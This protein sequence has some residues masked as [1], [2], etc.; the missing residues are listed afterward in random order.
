ML[1]FGKIKKGKYVK[2]IYDC[3]LLV[4]MKHKYLKILLVIK[5]WCSV[6]Y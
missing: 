5:E 3:K 1:G 4:M 2:E 6:N